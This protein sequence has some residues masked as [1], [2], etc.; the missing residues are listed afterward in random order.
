LEAN[1]AFDTTAFWLD[2]FDTLLFWMASTTAS[3]T[4][5]QNAAATKDEVQRDPAGVCFSWSDAVTVLS[6]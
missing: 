3:T 2:A 6:K 5:V 4:E 1:T